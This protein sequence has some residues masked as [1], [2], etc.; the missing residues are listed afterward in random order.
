MRV[1]QATEGLWF[2][3]LH[4]QGSHVMFDLVS[5]YPVQA[6]NWHD[7]ET[8]PSLSEALPRSP[9]AVIGG[10]HRVDS[11]LRGTPEQVQKEAKA[12]IE[13]TGGRRLILGTGCVMQVNTPLSNILAGRTVVDG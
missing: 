12:A 5:D 2:N 11:M 1:L 13:A 7:Q 3:V 10:L 6:I 9:G 4:L 8:P